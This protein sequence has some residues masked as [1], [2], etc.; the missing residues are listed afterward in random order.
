MMK[1]RLAKAGKCLRGSLRGLDPQLGL[2]GGS[3]LVLHSLQFV[4]LFIQPTD[5]YSWSDKGLLKWSPSCMVLFPLDPM[6]THHYLK[7][8][9]SHIVD[10]LTMCFLLLSPVLFNVNYNSGQWANLVAVR[11]KYL[12]ENTKHIAFLM[13]FNN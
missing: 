3:A 2:V 8:I 10:I 1:R 6:A 11:G 12:L 4:L 13:G 7:I 9:S 5:V